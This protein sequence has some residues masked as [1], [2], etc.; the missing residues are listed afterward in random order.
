MRSSSTFE[1]MTL[2]NMRANGVRSL[3]VLCNGLDCYRQKVLDI[4]HFGDDVAGPYF[5][6]RM[7]CE[8]C[9]YLLADARPNW[10]EQSAKSDRSS[11]DDVKRNRLSRDVR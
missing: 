6:P 7:R 5:G 1:P 10:A 11:E 8:A 4:D 9:G 2:G 3:A